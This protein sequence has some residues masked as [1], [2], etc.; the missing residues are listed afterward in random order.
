[1][2]HAALRLAGINKRYR[3]NTVLGP[4]DLSLEEGRIYG[5]IGENGAGKSTFIRI[6]MGLSKPTGGTVELMGQRGSAGL[7]N[8][9]SNIGYVPDSSASY[10]L[11]S[12]ADNLKV[13]CLEWGLDQ[14]QISRILDMVGLADAGNKRARSFSL[15]MRKRL[16]LG[17]A[18]L[19]QP[20]MLVLD[21]PTNGLDPL[22]TI[23]IRKLI[24]RLNRERG[25]TVLISS[26]NLAELHQTATDYVILS[27]G[28][29]MAELTA[30]DIER[31]SGGDLEKLYTRIMMGHHNGPGR[32]EAAPQH[33]RRPSK[34]ISTSGD[35]CDVQ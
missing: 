22:G 20:S 1:M 2:S 7:R 30:G 23:E 17:I 6:A 15:G 27:G 18:L 34:P 14:R 10:P 9:R 19:G 12:A 4:I 3:S 31:L 26:H 13:R 29:L 21:E 5:L 11:L 8:A 33:L 24:K 28:K 16:D 35:D 32:G 25:T